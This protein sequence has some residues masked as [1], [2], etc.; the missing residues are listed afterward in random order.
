MRKYSGLNLDDPLGQGML[1]LHFVTNSWSQHFTDI[2]KDRKLEGQKLGVSLRE[3]PDVYVKKDREKQKQKAKIML[4]TIGQI[5]QEKST[6]QRVGPRP[7]E[8]PQKGRPNSQASGERK[9]NRC[10]RCGKPEHFK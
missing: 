8:K 6:F 10:Y 7:V 2:S 5:T 1:R 3:T 9:R 4:S